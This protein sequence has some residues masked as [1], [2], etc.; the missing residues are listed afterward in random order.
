MKKR[1]NDQY[2]AY[3]KELDGRDEAAKKVKKDKE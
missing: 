3:I 1:E 2:L